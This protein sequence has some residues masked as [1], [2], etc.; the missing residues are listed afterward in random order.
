MWKGPV[1]PRPES[2]GPTLR[3]HTQAALTF[4]FSSSCVVFCL[5]RVYAVLSSIA[6]CSGPVTLGSHRSLDPDPSSLASCRDTF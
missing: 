2:S 3:A 5:H 1:R 4:L 6:H